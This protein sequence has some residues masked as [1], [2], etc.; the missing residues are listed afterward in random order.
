MYCLRAIKSGHLVS[1]QGYSGTWVTRCVAHNSTGKQQPMVISTEKFLEHVEFFSGLSDQSRK[2]IAGICAAREIEKKAVLFR[3][4]DP[5]H[6]VFFLVH[7]NVQLSKSGPDGKGVII[8]VLKDGDMFGEVVLFEKGAYPVTATV[9]RKSLLLLLPKAEFISALDDERFRA[10]FL[11]SMM[12]KMRYLAEKIKY[13]SL[14]DVDD[15]FRLFLVE[16]YGRKPLLKPSISKKEIAAAI[17]ATPETFSRLL[18]RLTSEKLIS[19]TAEGLQI[20]NEF[21]SLGD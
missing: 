19:W 11:A 13:L 20:S 4:G 6:S 9:M 12:R 14:H 5:G 16:Q 17:A 2:R 10:E 7:G 3:E 18:N 21:W 8:R 15:R 1:F